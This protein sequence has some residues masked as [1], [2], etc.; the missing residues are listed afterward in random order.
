MLFRSAADEG[1]TKVEN[2]L[3]GLMGKTDELSAT[4]VID[5]FDMDVVPQATKIEIAPV[6]LL[7]YDR[8][9]EMAVV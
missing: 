9:L 8:L 1:Q 4:K 7:S 5:M 2:I 6:D 3:R